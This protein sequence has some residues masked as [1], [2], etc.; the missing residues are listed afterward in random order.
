[1]PTYEFYCEKCKNS[2][3]II[4]SFSEYEKKK[5]SC[6]Q[7]IEATNFILSDGNFKKKLTVIKILFTENGINITNSLS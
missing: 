2:F 6:P 3:S 4:L 5:Y 7:K 1:M